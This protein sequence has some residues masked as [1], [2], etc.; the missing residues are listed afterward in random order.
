MDYPKRRR[1]IQGVTGNRA[2]DISVL[3]ERVLKSSHI[4]EDIHFKTIAEHFAEIVG[5]TVAPYVKL[6]KLDKQT[7]VLKAVNSAWKQELFLQ[8]N[9]IIERCNS[10]LGKP[11]IRDVRFV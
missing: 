10:M 8:K 4:S 1:S 3:V 9:A 5:N 11:V 7:L 6:E 2:V